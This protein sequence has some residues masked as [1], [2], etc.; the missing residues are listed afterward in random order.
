MSFGK[1]SIGEKVALGVQRMH[2][3]EED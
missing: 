1:K 2:E 3:E